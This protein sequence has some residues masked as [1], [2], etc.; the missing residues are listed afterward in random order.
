MKKIKSIK[1]LKIIGTIT[2]VLLTVV[3][4]FF[5]RNSFS[6]LQREDDKYGNSE[7]PFDGKY[8]NSSEKLQMS[9][10]EPFKELTIPYLRKRAYESVLEELDF[11]EEN[12]DYTSYLTNYDSDGFNINALITIPKG[13][14]PKDGWPGIIFVHG[15][16]PPNQ[17]KT[18]GNYAA[19]VD[20]LAKNGFVVFKTDLRGHGESE[21]EPGGAYY[22]SDY[23]VDT[24]NAYNALQSSNLVDKDN[25]G[26]WGHSMGGNIVF[27]SFVAKQD[28]KA[29]SIWAG[30]VYTYNDFSEYGISDNSYRPPAQEAESRRKRNELFDTYGSFDPQSEFW[31]KVVP[32]NYLGGL[33]GAVQLN[34][35]VD[36]NV[37]SIEYSRNL[38]SILLDTNLKYEVNEYPSGGH[39]ISGAS[40][41]NSMQDTVDFFKNQLVD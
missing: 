23:V 11:F 1:K 32:T 24:L 10:D 21:G 35:T 14:T 15:Y 39:N 5:L 33:T 28:I 2:G 30:A 40:F 38:S 13:D 3:V 12:S 7:K 20:Y 9:S 17:Y 22:S 31:I 16:V 8:E 29:V 41:N 6:K 27:R 4:V 34:H 25:I 36:D 18:I 37:V 26:L 19:Y